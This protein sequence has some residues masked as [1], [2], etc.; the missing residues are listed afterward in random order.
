MSNCVVSS[1][2]DRSGEACIPGG[3]RA[4]GEASQAGVSRAPLRP[5][6]R[7]GRSFPKKGKHSVGVTRQYSGQ[8][9]KQDNC[10]VAVSLSLANAGASF[11]IAYSLYLPKDWAADPARRKKAGVAVRHRRA[12]ERDRSSQGATCCDRRASTPTSPDPPPV[13]DHLTRFGPQRRRQQK[14]PRCFSVREAYVKRGKND[15]ADAEAICE[16]VARPTM[17]FVAVKTPEQQSTMML[18]HGSV[19]RPCTQAELAE[20]AARQHLAGR[21]ATA[22]CARCWLSARRTPTCAPRPL[23]RTSTRLRQRAS[24]LSSR[25]CRRPLRRTAT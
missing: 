18:H 11:P 8:L 17:R 16:A 2:Q 22:I 19:D 20:P 6:P 25:R 5:M 12:G 1:A 3:S 4:S 24:K 23:G 21:Q 7:C 10:Q 13:R 9:G 14:L 15:A